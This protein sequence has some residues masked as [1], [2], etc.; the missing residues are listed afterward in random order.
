MQVHWV[1]LDALL[2]FL[3]LDAG[4]WPDIQQYL[5]FVSILNLLY[6][7]S[8]TAWP[9]MYSDLLINSSTELG[10]VALSLLMILKKYFG[11]LPD[12]VLHVV[13]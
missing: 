10:A 1:L 5:V 11:P 2:L 4:V 3:S 7:Y 13:F 8:Q 6:I 9:C 12:V